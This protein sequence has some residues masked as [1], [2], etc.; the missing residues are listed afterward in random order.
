MVLSSNGMSLGDTSDIA[1]SSCGANGTISSDLQVQ[2]IELQYKNSET[3]SLKAQLKI[4]ATGNSNA[5]N[6]SGDIT[7]T[8]TCSISIDAISNP[9]FEDNTTKGLGWKILTKR[10]FSHFA[11]AGTQAN[12]IDVNE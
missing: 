8:Q 6:A 10:S 3:D 5:V 7:S 9:I 1:G 12:V 2:G 11:L 4:R